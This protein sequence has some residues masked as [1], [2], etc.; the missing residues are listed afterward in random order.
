MTT[1]LN[2][3][4]L[5]VLLAASASANII[6]INGGES[7]S[8]PPTF[9]T[10]ASGSSPL[11]LTSTPCCGVSNSFIVAGTAVG[12]PPLPSGTLDTNTITI[13]T[14]G[15]GTLF[16]W[17]TETGLTTPVANITSGLTANL[18]NGAISSVTL[19]TFLSPTNSISPPNGT[20]I[21]TA[22]FTAIGTQ[23]STVPFSESGTYSLQTLYQITATGVGNVN[24]TIDIATT[25]TPELG[26]A[27]LLGSALV[28]TSLIRK[29]FI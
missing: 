11:L 17:I 19:S 24:L 12:T 13:N 1:K 18:I 21:D 10:L 9:Q 23:T 22:T 26:T 7:P 2:L 28:L 8:F 3:M 15:A 29:R 25:D 14:V 5:V 4:A 27:M 6:T 20:L 16:I